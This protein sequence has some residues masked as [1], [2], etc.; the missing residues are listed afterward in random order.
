MIHTLNSRR[1]ALSRAAPRIAALLMALVAALLFLPA[2]ALAQAPAGVGTVTVTRADGALTASWNAPGNAVAYHIT[3]STDNRASWALGA[4]DHT[5]T[6]WTLGSADN[7]KTYIIGVRARN[8]DNEWGGWT[9]SPSAGPYTPPN[10]PSP[11]GGVGAITVTRADGTITASWNAV[12]N[13]TKYHITYSSRTTAQSWAAPPLT[14][15]RTIAGSSVT[16][17]NADNAKTYFIGARAGNSAGWSGWKNSGAR[18]SVHART[19]AH[20]DAHARHHRAGHQRQRHHHPV[21]LRRQRGKLP[22]QA[23]FP[24]HERREGVHRPVGAG[25]QRPRHHFQGPSKRRRGN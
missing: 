24:Y 23:R 19:D 4:M 21:R 8:A 16:I 9:N 17:D 3:Y 22:G 13:A 15:T 18:G 10:N 25:Q 14:A 6:T 11:P 2:I 7:A 12:S 5:G 20:T 1:L